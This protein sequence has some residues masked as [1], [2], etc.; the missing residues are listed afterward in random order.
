MPNE[1]SAHDYRLRDYPPHI[2]K[3]VERFIE[4]WEDCWQNSEQMVFWK[5]KNKDLGIDKVVLQLIEMGQMTGA[6]PHVSIKD[7]IRYA[8]KTPSP[9]VTPDFVQCYSTINGH[10]Y[11]LEF[12]PRPS[13]GSLMHAW[14]MG[15]ESEVDLQMHL[16]VKGQY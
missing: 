8:S 7:A 16:N 2:G 5:K 4:V 3:T 13:G 15:H 12:N 14:H 6:L 11:K 10:I 1:K 9:L